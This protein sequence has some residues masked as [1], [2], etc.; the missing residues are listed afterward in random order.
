MTIIYRTSGP[1]GVGLGADLSAVQVDNN[2]W[3]LHGRVEILEAWPTP[4]AIVGFEIDGNQLTVIMDDATTHGPYTLPTYVPSAFEWEPGLSVVPGQ[5]FAKNATIYTVVLPHIT[6]DP[7]DPNESST[8]GDY[9]QEFITVEGV[10]P[11][12]GAEGQNLVKSSS[13]DYA[14]TWSFSTI[15]AGGTTGQ[16]LKKVSDA[17][18]DRAWF[19][20][21]LD[22]ITDVDLASPTDGQF[23]VY[24]GTDETWSNETFEIEADQLRNPTITE[25]AGTPGSVVIDASLGDVFWCDLSGDISLTFL[26]NSMPGALVTLEF[27]PNNAALRTVTFGSTIRAAGDTF[28]VSNNYA[29][30]I[31][32]RNDGDVWVETGRMQDE[33]LH[34]RIRQNI[35][36]AAYT[37]TWE[38]SGCHILHPSADTTARIWTIPANSSVVFP[39][40]TT[41]TFVNQNGAGVITIAITTDTMRLAG[42]GTTGSR[43]LAANG[44]ATALK[45]T[46]TE[47]IISGTG[48][49]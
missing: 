24:N 37:L 17:D 35:K 45:I 4:A 20:N 18:Y 28:E 3:D 10:L 32:F 23:L 49:T 31:T 39:I 21:A 5:M 27:W 16:V 42:A 8:D 47:W 33:Q 26:D 25:F 38:D 41:I 7:F 13:A 40:G 15:P 6:V 1:W 36:S 14:V 2:F 19:D 34:H 46:A 11:T 29:G 12:G 44:I 22:D 9:Y 48:L 30:S 43:T